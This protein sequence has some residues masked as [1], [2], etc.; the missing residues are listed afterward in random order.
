MNRLLLFESQTS[1]NKTILSILCD[2][3]TER[4]RWLIFLDED[5][6][7]WACSSKPF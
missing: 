3:S 2:I 7:G 1:D 4:I 6:I 5:K